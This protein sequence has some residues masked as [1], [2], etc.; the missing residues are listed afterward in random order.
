MTLEARNGVGGPREGW[1]E[2]GDGPLSFFHA[3]HVEGPLYGVPS[4]FENA[5]TLFF[6]NEPEEVQKMKAGVATG[7][8]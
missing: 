7:S 2:V 1:G 8:V 4:A 5:Q 6:I 3:T